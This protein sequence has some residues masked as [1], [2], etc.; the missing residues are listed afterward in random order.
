M[1]VNVG[2]GSQFSVFSSRCMTVP[3]LET[4][5]MP[6]GGWLLAG[7][8]LCGAEPKALLADF[9]APTLRAS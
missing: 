5:P 8:A 2:T 3:G 4:R 9:F 7:A 1:L 6:G